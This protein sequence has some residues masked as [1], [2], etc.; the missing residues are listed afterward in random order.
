MPVEIAA[1]FAVLC[2]FERAQMLGL[3]MSNTI[4]LGCPITLPPLGLLAGLSKI[5]NV[6]HSCLDGIWIQ[7]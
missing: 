6:S 4:D 7:P 3:A 1:G 2:I 5:Y